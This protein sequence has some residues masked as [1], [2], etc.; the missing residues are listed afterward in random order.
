[1]VQEYENGKAVSNQAHVC[2]TC[3]LLLCLVDKED[4]LILCLCFWV[5]DFW[6]LI[7]CSLIWVCILVIFVQD[8]LRSQL[9]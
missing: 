1:M 2:V 6:I 3:L 7:L 8:T 9:M 5:C 4:L